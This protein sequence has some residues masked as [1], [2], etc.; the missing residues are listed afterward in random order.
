MYRSLH[1]K[2]AYTLKQKLIYKAS[3]RRSA[4]SDLVTSLTPKKKICSSETGTNVKCTSDFQQDSVGGSGGYSLQALPFW[5]NGS[6]PH[7]ALHFLALPS[8]HILPL[9][10]QSVPQPVAFYHYYC[11]K[12]ALLVF[13]NCSV[14]R[15]E[16]CFAGYSQYRYYTLQ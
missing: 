9:A 2:S 13:V 7:L 10:W 8:C 11:Q 6:I 15:T 12:L 14:S 16:K 5:P 3:L 4:F 1:A